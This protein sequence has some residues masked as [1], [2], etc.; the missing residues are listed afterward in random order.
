MEAESTAEGM[1]E[2]DASQAS[3]ESRSLKDILYNV[4]NLRKRPGA[5]DEN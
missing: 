5:D 1:N 2:K 4:E 3:T